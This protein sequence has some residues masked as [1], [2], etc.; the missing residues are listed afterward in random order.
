MKAYETWACTKQSM[1][2]WVRLI[3]ERLDAARAK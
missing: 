2:H 3:R 1:D